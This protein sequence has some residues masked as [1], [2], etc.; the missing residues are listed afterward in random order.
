MQQRKL[1]QYLNWK[2]TFFLFSRSPPNC[3]G[4]PLP[5]LSIF[6]AQYKY[7]E[8]SLRGRKYV[9]KALIEIW[10]G[11][12]VKFCDQ[13]VFGEFE[14]F[15]KSCKFLHGKPLQYNTRGL[16]PVY[17][18]FFSPRV[19]LFHFRPTAF[20]PQS[21]LSF[22]RSFASKPEKEK[23]KIRKNSRSLILLRIDIFYFPLKIETK[24]LRH[25]HFT[26]YFKTGEFYASVGWIRC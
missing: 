3:R 19:S 9:S 12:F 10:P 1:S 2:A 14:V 24:P 4:W 13:Y 7:Q 18:N 26:W 8:L 6:H 21:D 17:T 25:F 20:S 11:N 22:S 23:K 5:V 15:R 16:V